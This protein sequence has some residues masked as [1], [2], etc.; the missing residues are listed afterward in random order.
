MMAHRDAGMPEARSHDMLAGCGSEICDDSR[1]GAQPR[2]ILVAEGELA[3]G[4]SFIPRFLLL[5]PPTAV[6]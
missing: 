2:T 3:K 5:V 1:H 4:S 6:S